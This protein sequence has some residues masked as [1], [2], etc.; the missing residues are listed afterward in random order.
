MRTSSRVIGFR[1]SCATAIGRLSPA[2]HRRPVPAGK[3]PANRQCSGG[4]AA[5]AGGEAACLTGPPRSV[6]TRL[7]GNSGEDSLSASSGS[8]RSGS[9]GDRLTGSMHAPRLSCIWAG[10]MR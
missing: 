9:A 4:A 5:H 8:S 3:G 7:A 2:P 6:L 10:R 1:P